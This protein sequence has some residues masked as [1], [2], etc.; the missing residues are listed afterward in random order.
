MERVYLVAPMKTGSTSLVSL[1]RR[2]EW[3]A[4]WCFLDGWGYNERSC[5]NR[6]LTKNTTRIEIL[7]H[8]KACL[9]LNG[10]CPLPLRFETEIESWGVKRLRKIMTLREPVARAVSL[11]QHMWDRCEEH[12]TSSWAQWDLVPVRENGTSAN[13][14]CRDMVGMRAM[15]LWMLNGTN[16]AARAA[17][18]PEVNRQAKYVVGDVLWRKM[19]E[20]GSRQASMYAVKERLLTF[21]TWVVLEEFNLSLLVLSRILQLRPPAQYLNTNKR[22]VANVTRKLVLRPADRAVIEEQYWADMELYAYA[23]QRLFDKAVHLFGSLERARQCSRYECDEV[24]DVKRGSQ[25]QRQTWCHLRWK[26]EDRCE[27]LFA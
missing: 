13:G 20:E 7:A 14:D 21:D 25:N 19:E 15:F 18:R 6:F 1:L 24:K 11:W 10:H 5:F 8:P 27:D 23:L 9:V 26:P 4:C 22:G 17:M 12:E 16:A 2:P 3:L